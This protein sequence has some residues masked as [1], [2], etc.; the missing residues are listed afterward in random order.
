MA[1]KDLAHAELVKLH[2]DA[3]LA[4]AKLYAETGIDLS[5]LPAI[6]TAKELA[7]VLNV[8]V[9]S[10]GAGPVSRCRHPLHQNGHAAF[11]TCGLT[12]AAI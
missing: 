10:L 12:W 8:S 5:S 2:A 6:A 11:D 1:A 4:L 7:P 9:G 3:E